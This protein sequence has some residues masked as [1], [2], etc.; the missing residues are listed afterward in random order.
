[1]YNN[2]ELYLTFYSISTCL[3]IATTNER[4]IKVGM[5]SD[6]LDFVRQAFQSRLSS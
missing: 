5:L 6:Y 1:M 3:H 2:D 4:S